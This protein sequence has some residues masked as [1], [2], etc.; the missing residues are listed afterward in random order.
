MKFITHLRDCFVVSLHGI[1]L[2]SVQC[3]NGFPQLPKI[4]SKMSSD[5]IMQQ[6]R[7]KWSYEGGPE[8]N[9]RL[10]YLETSVELDLC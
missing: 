1:A 9:L 6:T 5:F 7:L 2:A 10:N 8:R 3:V 4:P